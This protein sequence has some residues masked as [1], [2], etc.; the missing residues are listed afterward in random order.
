MHKPKKIGKAYLILI[1]YLFLP[2]K[3]GG[4]FFSDEREHFISNHFIV[5]KKQKD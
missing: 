5:Y 1:L 3:I 2:H 4:R